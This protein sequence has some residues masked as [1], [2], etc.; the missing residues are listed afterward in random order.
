MLGSLLSRSTSGTRWFDAIDHQSRPKRRTA[1]RLRRLAAAYDVPDVDALVELRT[2]IEAEIAG[3]TASEEYLLTEVLAELIERIAPELD[4]H[5]D[6]LVEAEIVD[7]SEHVEKIA[8]VVSLFEN[9][10]LQADVEV[11]SDF[12]IGASGIQQIGLAAGVPIGDT[13]VRSSCEVGAS[14]RVSGELFDIARSDRNIAPASHLHIGDNEH[15]DI[16]MQVAGGG[17]ALR[18]IA[19]STPVTD[20]SFAVQA[21]DVIRDIESEMLDRALT[22]YHSSREPLELRRAAFAGASTAL[23]PLALT[24][25]AVQSALED[26]ASHL[27]YMSRE[28]IF[29]QRV[30]D[31]VAAGR[32]NL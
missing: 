4:G 18:V 7:E 32:S 29:L 25:M 27:H 15:S 24:T 21:D 23:F 26:G 14:K 17:A 8:E 6:A 2:S 28:G 30:H 10:Q 16:G 9:A 12:Y 5:V 20:A 19:S 13:A 1:Q 22:V 31:Q 3:R 11:L